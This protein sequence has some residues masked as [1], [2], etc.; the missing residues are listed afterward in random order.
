MNIEKHLFCFFSMHIVST[1]LSRLLF[2]TLC[3]FN[4][5]I[6][7]IYHTVCVFPCYNTWGSGVLSRLQPLKASRLLEEVRFLY[8][9][10]N[11]RSECCFR[12]RR[13]LFASTD[14]LI[15]HWLPIEM[16]QYRH[17]HPPPLPPVT[18]SQ[19]V[20]KGSLCISLLAARRKGSAS[21]SLH[22]SVLN[23]ATG[24]WEMYLAKGDPRTL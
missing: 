9:I 11:A 23:G 21:L 4:V 12:H 2:L 10:F 18:I 3:I 5:N 15:R 8:S 13:Q 19:V 16:R 7:S 6:Y 20:L 24:M 14:R 22:F 1:L 17:C